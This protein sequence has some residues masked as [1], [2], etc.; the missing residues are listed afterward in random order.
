MNKRIFCFVILIAVITI[1]VNQSFAQTKDLK[2]LWQIGKADHSDAEFALAPTG[3]N[4]FLDKDF[5]WENKFYLIGF[6][7][8][9]EDW[10]Y[11]L[12]GP[13]DNWG[14]SAGLAGWR[15]AVENIL[16]GINN[17]PNHGMFEL[18]IGLLD[19][20]AENPPKLKIIVNDTSWEFYLPKGSG[21]STLKGAHS[22]YPGYTVNVA[23][24]ARIFKKGGN[25]IRI[26]TIWGSWIVFYYINLKGPEDVQISKPE[27]AFI[28]NVKAA[29]YEIKNNGNP[30][31]P[32]LIDV[33]HLS[34]KPLL[35]AY[36]DGKEIF[37]QKIEQGRYIFE[38]PMPAVTVNKE[39][40]YE[41][42]I[43]NRIVSSGEILRSPQK[44]ITPAGYV[45][46]MLGSAHS[47]WMI[48][49][50]P[51]MPF[52]MVKLSP[53]NQ[54]AGWDAGYDPI[55]ENVGGF[56]HIHEW[57]MSGLSML[58]VNGP[59]IT[60]VGDQEHPETGY[61]SPIDKW[62]EEAPLG[63]YRVHLLKYNIWAELTATTRCSFQRYTFPAEDT[64]RVLV[65]FT[66]P[67]E[68]NY[69]VQQVEVK[70]INDHTIE[71][72]SKQLAPNVWGNGIDQNYTIHFVMQFDQPIESFSY[73]IDSTVKRNVAELKADSPNH[74]G[75][76]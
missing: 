26:T 44:M 45:N 30:A 72:F 59:L 65:D 9:K 43:D 62:T 57:T 61:R 36:L 76:F 34:G 19:I 22:D 74:V 64:S 32:L 69:H 33:Q 16:F 50:G 4:D 46:T 25:E 5:G 55:F 31:Q 7:N 73:W 10:P 71:G 53:D 3:Y 60:K 13:S 49:P 11:A 8:P 17:L 37:R 12:P 2:T 20:S 14:G 68:Y 27:N 52:G 67:A 63:Y 21:D 66:T 18:N 28:R 39:S 23:I 54:N 75:V 29:G 40:H 56:S 51:W 24:P 15:A 1:S 38:A 58:P 41:I 47:R 70:K 48:A 42:K 35:T 6:S